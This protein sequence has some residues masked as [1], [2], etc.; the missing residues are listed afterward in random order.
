MLYRMLVL[1]KV[2]FN[3]YAPAI[4][5][6]AYDLHADY[7]DDTI[8]E[9]SFLGRMKNIMNVYSAF[10]QWPFPQHGHGLP[11]AWQWISRIL[12][13]DPRSATATC[14]LSFLEVY[15]CRLLL[16]WYARMSDIHWSVPCHV[17]RLQGLISYSFILNK[18]PRYSPSFEPYTFTS[19]P[20]KTRYFYPRH[21]PFVV[22]I[23]VW[24]IGT[25]GA[26]S[27]QTSNSIMAAWIWTERRQT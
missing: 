3:Y 23:R 25:I 13:V 15:H 16:I 4:S 26:Q 17:N 21:R 9:S 10:M 7:I 14:L 6:R 20:H 8:A 2:H 27:C 1:L 18:R 22:I 11:A 5:P 19:Y 12:N 24:C